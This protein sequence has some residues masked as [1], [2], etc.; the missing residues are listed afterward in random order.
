MERLYLRSARRWMAVGFTGAVTAGLLQTVLCG[1]TPPA[2]PVVSGPCVR[3]VQTHPIPLPDGSTQAGDDG[4]AARRVLAASTD[5]APQT[6]LR[7][8][9][10]SDI[11]AALDTTQSPAS[12][13]AGQST[14]GSAPTV[15][16]MKERP[17]APANAAPTSTV[18]V[19]T[20]PA[21]AAPGDSGSTIVIAKEGSQAP[22]EIFTPTLAP[23][24]AAPVAHLSCAHP[25]VDSPVER[26]IADTAAPAPDVTIKN[27]P[28]VATIVTPSAPAIPAPAKT[29]AA[30][31]VAQ[32]RPVESA[33]VAAPPTLAPPVAPTPK[34]VAA[35]PAAAPA[36]AVPM[37]AA[38]VK[39]PVAVAEA[40][41]AP[42]AMRLAA[43]P[44]P[45][46]PEAPTMT[47]LAAPPE[48]APALAPNPSEFRPAAAPSREVMAITAKAE[49]LNRHAFQLAE[50]GA[51]Y[52]ARSEFYEALQVLAIGLDGRSDDQ[53][54]QQKLAEGLRA[55]EEADDFALR[56]AQAIEDMNISSIVE[57][58]RTPVLKDAD[59][60]KMSPRT[61]MSKYLNYAGEQLVGAVGHLQAGSMSLY[62]LGKIYAMPT[63][64]RGPVDVTGGAKA[65]LYQQAA[66]DVDP[67]NWRAAN[68]LGAQLVRFGRLDE[69]KVAFLQSLK[70]SSQ[71][72]VWNNLAAIHDWLG[73]P[74]LA[75]QARHMAGVASQQKGAAMAADVQWV[76]ATT[77]ARAMPV[78]MDPA[79]PA[80][81]AGA[82]STVKR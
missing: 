11:A 63:A 70:F 71:P 30:P 76:D 42:P 25:V 20:V 75:G 64:V 56:D 77:F 43:S 36:P 9:S 13:I 10:D 55:L 66:L 17:V 49:A 21:N 81:A 12:K 54:H 46:L 62:G 67:R 82:T 65:M 27:A 78:D 80:V 51:I 52:A 44:I 53:T 38:P 48:I 79:K 6:V 24:P 19:T 50:R 39:A 73:Q 16:V 47:R 1:Q 2:A 14:D 59:C 5:G 23:R 35:I 8:A 32:S 58:H 60:D 61:A 29:P 37:A 28:S 74:E 41:A 15:T 34:A 4:V 26:P 31:I 57:G 3:F 33:V 7:V 22:S 68:E 72:A 40:P 45:A 18:S 69:A